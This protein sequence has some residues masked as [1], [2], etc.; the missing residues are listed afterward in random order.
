MPPA[1]GSIVELGRRGQLQKGR[2]HH[3]RSSVD[4]RSARG[5]HLGVVG[6]VLALFALILL[7]ADG[8]LAIASG[9]VLAVVSLQSLV[10]EVWMVYSSLVAKPR[11]W[12]QP[13]DGAWVAGLSSVLDLGPGRGRFLAMVADRAP[14]A[15]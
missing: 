5:S 2:R 9:V 12:A 13:L 11:M 3:P 1:V 8:W 14:D 10:Q 15:L 6:L 7:Q 4:R